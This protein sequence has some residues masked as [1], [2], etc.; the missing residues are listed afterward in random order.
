MKEGG[1]RY[2]TDLPDYSEIVA[3]MYEWTDNVYREIVEIT[4]KDIPV[5]LYFC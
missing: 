4:P 2:R 1:I 5:P 3:P